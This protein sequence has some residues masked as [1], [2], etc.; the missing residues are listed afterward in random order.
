M[1]TSVWRSVPRRSAPSAA[2]SPGSVG[3]PLVGGEG[4][5]ALQSL[6]LYGIALHSLLTG[7]VLIVQPDA[8]M[9]WAGWGELRPSFFAAQGGVFHVLMVALYLRAAR[10]SRERDTL[11]PYILIV[12]TAAAAFLLSYYLFVQGFPL[13]LAAGLFDGGVAALLAAMRRRER[14]QATRAAAR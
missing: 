3:F 5:G 6:V 9:R 1:K 13:I 12:K 10:R 4:V 14:R 11:I 2:A 8:F 7:I